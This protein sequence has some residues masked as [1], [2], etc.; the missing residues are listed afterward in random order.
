MLLFLRALYWI[1]I[2]EQI[3]AALSI[4]NNIFYVTVTGNGAGAMG[5]LVMFAALLEKMILENA[6]LFYHVQYL[7]I[8][9]FPVQLL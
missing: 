7:G 6:T 4:G 3:S 8:F 1:S 2:P 5:V 9:L